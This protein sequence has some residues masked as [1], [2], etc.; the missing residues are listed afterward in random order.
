MVSL[1]GA[2]GSLVLELTYL[3]KVSEA[4]FNSADPEMKTIVQVVIG[5]HPSFFIAPHHRVDL[6]FCRS[7]SRV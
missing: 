4:N 5:N 2:V 1:L 7:G 6:I 3:A